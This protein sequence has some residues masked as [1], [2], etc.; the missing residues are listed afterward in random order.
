[1]C[2]PVKCSSCGKTSWGGC[3]RHVPSV[4]AKIPEGQACMC[5]AWPEVEIPKQENSSDVKTETSTSAT[6]ATRAAEAGST[7]GFL[8]YLKGFWK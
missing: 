6:S 3:G 2:Y 8:S 7:S 5:K 4:Y 1:M